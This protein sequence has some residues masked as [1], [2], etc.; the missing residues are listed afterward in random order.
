[1]RF[2]RRIESTPDKEPRRIVRGAVATITLV[3]L[4]ILTWLAVVWMI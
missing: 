1:M 2:N 3:W 4:M